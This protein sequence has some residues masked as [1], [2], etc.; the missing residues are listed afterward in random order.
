MGS[1]ICFEAVVICAVDLGFY[2][3][4]ICGILFEIV[5]DFIGALSFLT[6]SKVLTGSVFSNL[7]VDDAD[8]SDFG[9]LSYGSVYCSVSA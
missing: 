2:L 6:G 9:S 4:Y 8:T 3:C 5:A 1:D 7:L